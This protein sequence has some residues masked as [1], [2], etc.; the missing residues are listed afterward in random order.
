MNVT[1][2]LPSFRFKDA[3]CSDVGEVALSVFFIPFGVRTESILSTPTALSAA[4]STSGLPQSFRFGCRAFW[5]FGFGCRAFWE[6][7]LLKRKGQSFHL[8]LGVTLASEGSPV[9]FFLNLV[10]RYHAS[11]PLNNGY[12]YKTIK[13]ATS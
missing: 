12:N 4:F 13:A 5:E 2:F 10:N 3:N 7:V 8:P 6:F 11:R 1:V 9:M